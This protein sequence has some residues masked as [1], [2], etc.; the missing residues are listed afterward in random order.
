MFT[1]VP[2]SC[3]CGSAISFQASAESGAV[4][5]SSLHPTASL[6]GIVFYGHQE[7]HAYP[8]PWDSWSKWERRITT[9]CSRTAGQSKPRRAPRL[10]LT[11]LEQPSQERLIFNQIKKLTVSLF[12]DTFDLGVNKPS[13]DTRTRSRN[14]TRYGSILS[15]R[16]NIGLTG[17]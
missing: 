4:T 14:M 7:T 11:W 15:L 17:R 6:L 1:V 8:L 10:V 12:V 3:V 9:V 13:G 2:L 16:R 5:Q